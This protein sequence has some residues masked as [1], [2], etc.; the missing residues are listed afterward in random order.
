MDAYLSGLEQRVQ[1]GGSLTGLESVASFFI[2]R[3]DTEIDRRLEKAGADPSLKGKV[4]LAKAQLA[5]QAYKEVF[6]SGRWRTLK[7]QGAKSQRPLWASTGVKNQDYPDTL[8]VSDFVA[9]DSVNTMP[10]KILKS[11]GDH[12]RSW[13][14][15]LEDLRRGGPGHE[16]RGR[17][18][19]RL[20]DVFGV[21]EDEGLQKFV[22]SWTSSPSQS[23]RSS[24]TRNEETHRATQQ[25]TA[26]G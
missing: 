23:A 19:C 3:V 6:S 9:P 15:H 2:S 18:R 21:L 26:P 4:A 12:G 11:Y 25:V 22:D 5:Y 24:K 17:C 7:A 10:E 20:D 16:G 8:Y 1:D 14:A 13:Q